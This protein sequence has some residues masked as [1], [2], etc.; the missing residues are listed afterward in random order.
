M[1]PHEVLEAHS[2]D[3]N[4]NFQKD[5]LQ[6]IPMRLSIKNTAF[7]CCDLQDKFRKLIYGFDSVI[8]TAQKMISASKILNVPLIVTEQSPSKLG[9]TASEL[10]ISSAV[11]FHEKTKFSMMTDQVVSCV[12][13]K[14]LKSIVL[15]GIESH[16]CI[17]QTTLDCLEMGIVPWIV[18]DGVSSMN[19]GEVPIALERLSKA[20][21]IISS[22][23]SIIFEL[24][25]DADHSKFREISNLIKQSSVGTKLALDTLRIK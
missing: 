12:Q 20:G 23:D 4:A 17:S 9:S 24:L 3:S 6:L 2:S 16:V 5:V 1:S 11:L 8:G 7:F 10:D 15:F 21:A 19:Y 18:A 22:S 25:K 13:E 14:D